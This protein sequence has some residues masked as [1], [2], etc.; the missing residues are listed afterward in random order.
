MY[1]IDSFLQC[2]SGIEL[3]FFVLY[4]STLITN[5]HA[6]KKLNNLKITVNIIKPHKTVL[7]IIKF[8]I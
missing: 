4:K 3:L 5:Y 1:E 8:W 2:K 6:I 7:P